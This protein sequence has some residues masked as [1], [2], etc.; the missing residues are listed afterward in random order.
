VAGALVRAQTTIPPA[1]TPDGATAGTAGFA[2]SG[3][4]NDKGLVSLSLLPGTA[5]ATLDYT[6][7]VIP[8]AA[9]AYA[10]TCVP[11][12]AVTVGGSTAGAANLPNVVL[13]LR[14]LLTGTV[15]G[16][17][18]TPASAVAVTATA[19][20]KPTGACAST[21]ATSSGT[22]TDGLGGFSLPLD[23]GTYQLDYDPPAGAAVPRFTEAGVVVSAGLGEI[24]HDVT[25]P[26]AALVRGTV[27][28]PDGSPLS[29]ANVLFF[30]V[31]CGGPDDCFGPNRTAPWLRAETTTDANGAFLAVV[32]APSA[33]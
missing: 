2:R 27:R 8:P 26:A 1:T 20:P 23:P 3:T 11:T 12:V 9:S 5:T 6:L 22:V 30:E 17:D 19:G 18:G 21:P 13:P 25:L 16:A 4:T 15:F 29:Q 14:P 10:T 7:T 32:P 31:R 33:N 24:Q 28:G